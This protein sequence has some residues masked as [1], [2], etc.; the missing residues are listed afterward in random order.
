MGS[1]DEKN[2]LYSYVNQIDY[3]FSFEFIPKEYQLFKEVDFPVVFVV[4]PYL[5]IQLLYVPDLLPELR[6]QYFYTILL[7]YLK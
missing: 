1:L 3:E 5:N 6:E 2:D 4:D 7:K